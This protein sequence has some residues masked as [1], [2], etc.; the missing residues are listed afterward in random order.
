MDLI[1]IIDAS[2]EEVKRRSGAWVVCGPGCSSCCLGPFAINELDA[3][4][5]RA[6]LTD[7]TGTDPARA[8]RI[9]QRTK[10]YLRKASQPGFNDE[11]CP[12]LDPGSGACDLYSARPVICRVFGPAAYTKG[13]IVRSCELCYKGA[14]E[15]EIAACA[16]EID[17][18]GIEDQLLAA[19][20]IP[21]GH[22]PML[23]ADA[24]AAW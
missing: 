10:E 18:D 7:L 2:M 17:P 12:V 6:G 21:G 13:G 3:I 5:L 8:A 16:V 4:R 14:T 24:L 19:M 11:P 15:E 9:R 23:I 1:Q 22:Q 20:D